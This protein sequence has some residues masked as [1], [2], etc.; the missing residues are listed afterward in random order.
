MP[1][2]IPLAQCNNSTWLLSFTR[3]GNAVS[4]SSSG[5]LMALARW[6]EL[7]SPA[8]RTSITSAPFLSF[9]SAS[10]VEIWPDSFIIKM[11]ATIAAITKII[12]QFIRLI[13]VVIITRCFTKLLFQI[14]LYRTK[15]SD[16]RDNQISADQKREQQP[17]LADRLRQPDADEYQSAGQNPYQ[18]V[19]AGIEPSA[20][21]KLQSLLVFVPPNINKL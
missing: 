8:L 16:A 18:A 7:N 21:K 20:C 4:I 19:H 14:V 12:V 2:R 10:V 17:P 15:A 5:M 3:F 13:L 9:S 1:L 11:T 6:P